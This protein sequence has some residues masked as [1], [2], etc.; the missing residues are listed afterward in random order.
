MTNH[1]PP[2][3]ATYL[4]ALRAVAST[5]DAAGDSHSRE[6]ARGLRLVA[7]L[8]AAADAT[9]RRRY[10]V[11]ESSGVYEIAGAATDLARTLEAVPADHRG[12]EHAAQLAAATL[13]GALIYGLDRVS[14]ML[15]P[16]AIAAFAPAP[17]IFTPVEYLAGSDA[18]ADAD[19]DGGAL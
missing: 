13:A 16:E 7:H 17:R 14:T 12:P 8:A 11:R 6:V 9:A 5:F 19:A 2:S 10:G 1:P 18:D 15:P 3:I 4:A